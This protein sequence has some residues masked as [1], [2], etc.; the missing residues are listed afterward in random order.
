MERV[1]IRMAHPGDGP[2]LAQLH[3]DTAAGLHKLDPSRFRIPDTEGLAE[4]LDEDLQTM[5]KAWICRAQWR[6]PNRLASGER[7][8]WLCSPGWGPLDSARDAAHGI[9]NLVDFL[10]IRFELI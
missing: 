8:L 7:T 2:G 1:T 6:V 3:L 4:W 5:G 10:G 9:D